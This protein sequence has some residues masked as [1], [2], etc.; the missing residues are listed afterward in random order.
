MTLRHA[1]A[2]AVVGWYLLTPVPAGDTGYWGRLHDLIF[3]ASEYAPMSRWNQLGAFDTAEKCDA[4]QTK[5]D[6][7]TMESFSQTQEEKGKSKAETAVDAWKKGV[8]DESVCIASD[9]PRLK[10]K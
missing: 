10:E 5:E 7:S 1:A 3:G 9:D 6:D 4:A 2:L 8:G